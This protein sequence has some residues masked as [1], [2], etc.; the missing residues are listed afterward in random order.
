[1]GKSLRDQLRDRGLVSEL[2]ANLADEVSRK[3]LASGESKQHAQFSGRVMSD[4]REVLADRKAAKIPFDKV[5]VE[6]KRQYGK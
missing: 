1:M 6:F 5:V 4:H 3:R 2:K